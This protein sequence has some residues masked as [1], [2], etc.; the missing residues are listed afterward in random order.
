MVCEENFPKPNIS[1]L[2]AKI[3]GSETDESKGD[4]KETI[5][6]EG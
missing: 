4:Q 5:L 6:R 3:K 2:T 1:I